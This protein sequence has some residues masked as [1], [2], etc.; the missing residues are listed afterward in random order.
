MRDTCQH[1]LENILKRDAF[2]IVAVDAENLARFCEGKA[3]SNPVKKH[4]IT[5]LLHFV[6]KDADA[7]FATI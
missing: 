6:R 3:R 5:G 4:C 7:E 2:R 1:F